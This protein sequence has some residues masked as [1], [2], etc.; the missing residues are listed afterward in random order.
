MADESKL[1]RIDESHW[2]Q[3][4]VLWT[5]F[6]FLNRENRKI[7][8]SDFHGWMIESLHETMRESIAKKLQSKQC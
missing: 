1:M 7:K 8:K 2:E 4:N 3:L 6:K 5:D